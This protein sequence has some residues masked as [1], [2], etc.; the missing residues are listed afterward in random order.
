[1]F[2]PE[3]RLPPGF[4]DFIGRRGE[5]VVPRPAATIVLMRDAAAG[6]E[7]LL[8]R[9]NRSSGFVPGAYVF[10]GGRV[11]EADADPSL[12]SGTELPSEPP[13]AYWTA[14]IRELFE[15]TGVLLARDPAGEFAADAS[16]EAMAHWR[17]SL[18]ED[19]AT[20][21]GMLESLDL[22][23]AVDRVVH[24]AHWITP[25]AE[26]RRYDTRFFLGAMPP[27]R[28]ATADAREMSDAVWLS[29]AAALE[30]FALGRLP[31]V[32]PTVRTLE[33][34]AEFE[35]VDAALESLRGQPVVPILPR[36]VRVDGG[37]Q[38]VVDEG[39]ERE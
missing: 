33:S 14:A 22:R 35:S 12:W 1:M 26:S 28:T 10:A 37:V 32:F 36:L 18:L 17:E 7:L 34:L 15:E 11:D 5:G 2:I 38:L 9:R 29:P 24:F 4:V 8:L 25:V 16:D 31:M 21:R 6:P 27:G 23:L 13:P 19:G 3:D 30:R 20:L 39:A